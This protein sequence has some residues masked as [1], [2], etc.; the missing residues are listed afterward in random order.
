VETLAV[1]PSLILHG[2]EWFQQWG[3]SESVGLKLFCL[4]GHVKN[5][6]VVEVPLGLTVREL[7]DRFGGGFDGDPQALLIGGAAGGFLR[8][9]QLDTPLS[10]EDLRPLDIPIGSGAIIVFNRTVDL[11]QVLEDLAYFFVHETCGHCAPCRLGTKQIYNILRRIN[12][13]DG[14]SADVKKIAK[15]GR[16]VR[17]TCVCGLGMT[18]ANPSLTVLHNLERAI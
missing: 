18:A 14:T 16:T 2:G 9:D 6:G 3:T 15:L 11:W 8:A 7:V 10:H 12:A 4:S 13:G 1:V 17:K 5:P